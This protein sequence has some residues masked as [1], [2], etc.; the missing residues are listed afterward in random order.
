MLI[1]VIFIQLVLKIFLVDYELQDN[2]VSMR[3]FTKVYI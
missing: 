3:T 1:K 2:I